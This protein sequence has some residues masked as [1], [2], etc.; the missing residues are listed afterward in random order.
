MLRFAAAACAGLG[1]GALW[2][3]TPV[4]PTHAV[5]VAN[6]PHKEH[7]RTSHHRAISAKL[8]PYVLGDIIPI[9]HDVA[10][11]RFLLD[12]PEDVFNLHP[13]STLQANF[14]SGGAAIDEVSRFYTPVTPNGTKGFFDIIVKR[15]PRGRMTSHLL[16]LHIGDRCNFRTVAFKVR[17]EP[18][19][20]ERIGLIAGGTGFTPMLQVIRHALTHTSKDRFGRE[21]AT[22]ISFLFCNRTEKHIL[23]RDM[24]DKLARQHP[25]R[26]AV[27]YSVDSALEPAKWD[28]YTGYITEDMLRETMPP[29]T[30]GEKTTILVCGP[31][32]LLNHAAGVPMGAQITLSGSA[33]AQPV[34]PDLNN[35]TALGGL[36]G[37][38]GYDGNQVYR[39]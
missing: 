34:A 27:H 17:Y 26:F 5:E 15:K 6:T 28:G 13:C 1:A 36:L 12:D 9:T 8:K 21:D 16:G 24:F 7:Y 39:F 37:K 32:K 2:A 30:L 11:L 22:K 20:W 33:H 35:L 14:R 31:D 29:P 19:R 3:G 4:A 38:L 25:D 18:N 23:L 10:L